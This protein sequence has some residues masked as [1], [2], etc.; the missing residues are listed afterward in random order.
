MGSVA[1]ERAAVLGSADSLITSQRSGAPGTNVSSSGG[2]SF[3]LPRYLNCDCMTHN[4]NKSAF[5][6]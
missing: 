4:S 2:V 3:A 1:G 5:E 6:C